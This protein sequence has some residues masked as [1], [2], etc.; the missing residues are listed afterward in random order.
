MVISRGFYF[1][2]MN[3]ADH[4]K[5]DFSVKSIKYDC[6]WL[7][8]IEILFYLFYKKKTIKVIIF[9]KLL[10]NNLIEKKKKDEEENNSF[11]LKLK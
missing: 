6:S 1:F 3:A 5:L 4:F 2:S 10:T 7:A 8:P 11:Q 9:S